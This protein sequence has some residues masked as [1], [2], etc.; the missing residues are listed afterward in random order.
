[1]PLSEH[2]LEIL[3]RLPALVSAH[4]SLSVAAILAGTAISV[5]L[6]I[7]C[8]RR[9]ALRGPLLATAGMVQAIPGIALLAL[10]VPVLAAIDTVSRPWLGIEV[11]P[12][13]FWP[14][15]VAL[16]LYSML[17]ILR[18]TVVG[19]R[20]L[21]PSVLEAATAMG[22]TPRQ[23]LRIVELP[24]A[25]PVLVSGLRTATVW[26]VGTATLATPVGGRSLGAFVFGGLQTRNW[27][28][29]VVGCVACAALAIG[30]DLLIGTVERAVAARRG[31]IAAIALLVATIAAGIAWPALDGGRRGAIAN[32]ARGSLASTLDRPVRIGA[33]TFT[34]QFVLA[35]VV[36]A[37]LGEAGFESEIVEGLGSTVLFDALASGEIDVCVDYS[38]TLWTNV[39]GRAAG[40]GAAE[41]RAE[42]AYRLALD[43]GIRVL[44]PLGFENAYALAL[45]R[46]IV[47]ALGISSIGDLAAHAAGWRIGGDYEFFARPEWRSI[48]ETYGLDPLEEV[49]LD[50][51]FMY[52]ACERGDVEAIAVFSSDGRIAAFDLATLADPL[53]AIPPYEALL[54]LGRE[55]ADDP[56][57]VEALRNMVGAIDVESMREANLLVD[58]AEDPVSPSRASAWLVARYR[59]RRSAS[60]SETDAPLE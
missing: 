41:V 10:M 2:L 12:L 30:L 26:T 23:R 54:L 13:G 35:R 44:G 18:N 6:G 37:E 31:R 24:L 7:A 33:K 48:R 3:Q 57:L 21:D 49:G 32:E 39:L 14:A 17:P 27:A 34:E 59:A 56:A 46:E 53:G 55:A 42:V 11:P 8:A 25:M 52:G 1:M 5:P 16:W 51:T 36:A 15:L 40:P 9:A 28:M 47:E 22:M 19:L 45:R 4:L 29:V 60:S 58:R 20:S 38:G 43:E 50:S